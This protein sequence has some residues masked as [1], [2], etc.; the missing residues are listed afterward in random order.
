MARTATRPRETGADWEGAR[1]LTEGDDPSKWSLVRPVDQVEPHS[2]PPPTLAASSEEGGGAPFVPTSV[3]TEEVLLRTTNISGSA[4]RLLEF[5]WLL[6]AL[7][8]F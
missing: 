1:R 7:S 6:A 3:A 4:Y 5:C 8:R 2:S